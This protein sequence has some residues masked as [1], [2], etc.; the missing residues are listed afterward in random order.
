MPIN[1]F[2]D[3]LYALADALDGFEAIKRPPEGCETSPLA[4]TSLTLDGVAVTP[5]KTNTG[6]SY[7]VPS[8]ASP[9]KLEWSVGAANPVEDEPSDGEP[10]EP[11]LEEDAPVDDGEDAASDDAGDTGLSPADP[12]PEFPSPSG[13][14]SAEIVIRRR[15]PG[16]FAPDGMF[17][18][19]TNLQGFDTPA[20]H[21]PTNN[22]YNPQFHDIEVFWDFGDPGSVYSAPVHTLP[23]HKNR[24]VAKGHQA[25]HVYRQPGSYTV[26]AFLVEMS[27]GKTA[28]ATLTISGETGAITDAV[29]DPDDVYAGNKTIFIGTPEDPANVPDGALTFPSYQAM[30]DALNKTQAMSI[31]PLGGWYYDFPGGI[32]ARLMF[33]GGHDEELTEGGFACRHDPNQLFFCS[34]P[35]SSVRPVLRP[36]NMK[37]PSDSAGAHILTVYHN[38]IN[39]RTCAVF[40]GVDVVGNWDPTIENDIVLDKTIVRSV[41]GKTEVYLLVDD[42][43]SSGLSL[44]LTGT[45]D[46]TNEQNTAFIHDS[47]IRDWANFGYYGGGTAYAAVCGSRITQNPLA[48][49]GGAKIRPPLHH[50]N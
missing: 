27:S 2:R 11:A 19:V 25:F 24:N 45:G 21:A 18:E 3:F 38:S 4:L 41:Y 9:Q 12:W 5:E 44:T 34:E 14:A 32:D 48:L 31:S 46:G 36:S 40:Q 26:T 10:E 7:T 13:D 20:A 42:I 33:A 47:H 22:L 17:F 50:N 30:H 23:E 28:T 8:S 37:G 35:G 39:P 15:N 6:W 16:K 49:H 1:K 29:K 43:V